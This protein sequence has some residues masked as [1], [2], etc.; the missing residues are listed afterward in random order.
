[1]IQRLASSETLMS[2]PPSVLE[3]ARNSSLQ[4]VQF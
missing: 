3:A 1:L 2:K 4:Y